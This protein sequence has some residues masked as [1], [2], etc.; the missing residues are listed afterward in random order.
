MRE[1]KYLRLALMFGDNNA[2][3][4]SKNLEKMISLVLHDHY[5]RPLSVV[6]II[7]ELKNS[8]GLEFSETEI[9]STINGKR[10]NRIICVDENKD[11]SQNKYSITPEAKTIIDSKVGSS[12][13]TDTAL[14]FLSENPDIKVNAVIF[15]STLKKYFYSV[16]NSNATTISEL[17]DKK[18]TTELES[19]I[20][21]SD[22][23][24]EQINTFLEWNNKAKDQCVY[25]MVSCCFDYCMMTVKR[26]KAIYQNMFR[27]KKFYLGK[28]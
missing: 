28:R 6:E 11:S 2:T 18:L 15:E 19:D 7:Y 4:F 5:E 13:I 21:F 1:S 3:T 27:Q 25:Q 8:Y 26:D 20:T 24:K 9:I 17:L 16:F 10:Q 23:E 12:V 14:L 22:S